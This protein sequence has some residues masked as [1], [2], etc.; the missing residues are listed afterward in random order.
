MAKKLTVVVI[1]SDESVRKTLRNQ[2]AQMDNVQVAEQLKGIEQ[3]FAV[4]Q[5]I[6]PDV[7]MLDLPVDYSQ[8]LKW[9]EKVKLQFPEMNIFVSSN[10]TTSELIMSAMRAGAQEFLVRPINPDELRKALQKVLIAKEQTQGGAPRSGRIISVFSKKGGLGVTTL[11]V[12][13]GVALSQTDNSKAALLDL[14]LQLGDITSF[15]NLSPDYNILDVLNERGEVD[16]VKLQSCMT[17]H[18]SGVFVLSEPNDP[19]ESENVSAQQ[20]GQVLRHLRSM[21]SYV[22]IDAPHQ[23][24]SRTLEAF[25]L[26]DHIIVVLAPNISS[27]RAAKKAL[28][29]F[30]S[31][32]YVRDKVRVIVNRAGKK[33]PIKADEIEKTLRYPVTW[34]VPNDYRAVI[35]AINSGV[36]LVSQDGKSNVAKSILGLSNDIRQ[37]KRSFHVQSED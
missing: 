29:V 20:I 2:L 10:L 8:T 27:I 15:L 6:R 9:T 34:V 11:A 5:R 37:W 13:L 14:D 33:D 25:E 36:P 1:D 26:S 28:A 16:G 4:V 18:E 12:N 30:K 17:R 22:V 3:G 7:L 23:F 19:A 32:G 31:L 24:D 35:E 21:F